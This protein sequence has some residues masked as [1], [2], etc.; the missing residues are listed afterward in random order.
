MAEA[1]SAAASLRCRYRLAAT[2]DTVADKRRRDDAD[3]QPLFHDA[4]AAQ[5]QSRD[6]SQMKWSIES[7]PGPRDSSTSRIAAQ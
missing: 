2:N 7:A 5:S 1:G 3:R 6:A 4:P